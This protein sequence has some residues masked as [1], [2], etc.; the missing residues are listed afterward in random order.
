ML[1]V[2]GAAQLKTIG[3]TP[4]RPISS[5]SIP[6]SQLVS[7][8]PKRSS[9]RN[10]FH[11]PSPF[12]RSR[13]STR[14]SGYGTP[15]RTSSSS[16]SIASRS[17][18]STCSS[19]NS[20]TRSRRAAT[21]SDGAKSMAVEPIRPASRARP[22]ARWPPRPGRSPRPARA[23]SGPCGRRWSGRD[24][25]AGAPR[26]PS[27]R[28]A[29]G[30]ST[31]RGPAARKSGTSKPAL[32]RRMLGTPH[33]SSSAWMNSAS[34]WLRPPATRTSFPSV[35]AGSIFRARPCASL[36][37]ASSGSAPAWTSGMPQ[38]GQKRAPDSSVPAA[39]G[40]GE[41][42]ISRRGRRAP[43]PPPSRRRSATRAPP[44]RPSA[45]RSGT[46]S[47]DTSARLMSVCDGSAGLFGCEW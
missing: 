36:S 5:H 22:P 38:L 11:S 43:P 37:G 2:S 6:Y 20:R 39:A 30:T 23:A 26:A 18:G 41:P 47:A 21:R 42:P 9:G 17:T 35:N 7:P 14:I 32:R 31:S 29:S 16:A 4:F 28:P 46:A 3:A 34:A 19:M 15:G 10:R 1:P 25:P 33:S 45:T 13:S 24:S 40:A 44:A 27:P 8:G 12:A